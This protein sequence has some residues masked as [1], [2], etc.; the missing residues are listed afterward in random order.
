[1]TT[2]PAPLPR[3]QVPFIPV[4]A[5]CSGLAS[6]VVGLMALGGYMTYYFWV[7]GLILDG[8]DRG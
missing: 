8:G 2:T 6:F 7:I 4:A 1:M 3:S 5:F